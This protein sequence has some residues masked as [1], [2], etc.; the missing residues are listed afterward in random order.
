MG[1]NFTEE[2]DDTFS[3]PEK[4]NPENC[5]GNFNPTQTVL[6]MLLTASLY[7]SS[8]CANWEPRVCALGFLLVWTNEEE[9]LLQD[10]RTPTRV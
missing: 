9:Y 4:A 10:I 7:Q 5:T 8:A 6:Y 2:G 1:F 3:L